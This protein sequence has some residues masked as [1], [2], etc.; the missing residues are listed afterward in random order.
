M[1]YGQIKRMVKDR[2]FG[3][4]RLEGKAGDFFFHKDDCVSNFDSMNE[5]DKIS[6]EIG[7]SPKGPRAVEVR[8]G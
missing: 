1:E 2:G 5:G 8:V 6:C 3:F 4:I 7:R